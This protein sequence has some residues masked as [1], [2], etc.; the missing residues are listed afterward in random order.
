MAALFRRAAARQVLSRDGDLEDAVIAVVRDGTV[1]AVS[2]SLSEDES[3]DSRSVELSIKVSIEFI[4]N[5]I[6]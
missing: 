3:Q 4:C 5:R 6:L 1:M 2:A